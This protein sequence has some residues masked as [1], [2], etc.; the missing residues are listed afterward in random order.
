MEQFHAVMIFRYVFQ[1][2]GTNFMPNS[3]ASSEVFHFRLVQK[4][5]RPRT[6]RTQLSTGSSTHRGFMVTYL[7]DKESV[8]KCGDIGKAEADDSMSSVVCEVNFD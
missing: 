6:T 1:H 4:N 5:E 3:C 2:D 8:I 7:A